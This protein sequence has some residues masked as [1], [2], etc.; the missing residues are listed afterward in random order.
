MSL[1]KDS[2][3]QDPWSCTGSGL[4]TMSS[5]ANH[6]RSPSHRSAELTAP[7]AEWRQTLAQRRREIDIL[8]R[9]DQIRE[10]HIQHWRE[11]I[12]RAGRVQ[13]QLLASE[14]LQIRGGQILSYT[15]PVEDVS[16]DFHW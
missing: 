5:S 8:K 16:G 15:Q 7:A 13:R 14:P 11:E 1:P 12:E 6:N 3:N 9:R 4:V 2:L 10:T